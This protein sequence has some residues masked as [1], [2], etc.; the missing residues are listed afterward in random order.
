M[1]ELYEILDHTA[2]VRIKVSGGNLDE[3]L[4]NCSLAMMDIICDLKTVEPKEKYDVSCEGGSPEE[5][6]V[7]WLSELLYLHEVK[8]MLFCECEIKVKDRENVAGI[9]RG[10]QIDENRH[11]LLTDIKAVTYSGLEVK[12]D[13]GM[14]SC[15]VTFDI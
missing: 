13:N 6:I 8:R 4:I 14:L 15:N 12:E 10:E 5:L 9:C 7:N 3:L 1:K 2:D 11:D